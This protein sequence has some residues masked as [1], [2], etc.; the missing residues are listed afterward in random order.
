VL[1]KPQKQLLLLGTNT[2]NFNLINNKGEAFVYYIHRPTLTG[3]VGFFLITP[4]IKIQFDYICCQPDKSS[5][6]LKL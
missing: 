4:H 2:S 3:G 1:L 6:E 5:C